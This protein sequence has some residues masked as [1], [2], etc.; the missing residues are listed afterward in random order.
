M[1]QSTIF[2]PCNFSGWLNTTFA[3]QFGIVDIDWSNNK[4]SWTEASPMNCQETLVE[5]AAAIKAVNPDTR[6]WVYR[7]LLRCRGAFCSKLP[8]NTNPPCAG[9]VA[10]ALP[11]FTDVRLKLDDPRYAG[12]FVPFGPGPWHVPNCTTT[13]G[14]TK[15]SQFYHD[16]FPWGCSTSSIC[17]CGNN[18]CGE[19]L[20]DFRNVTL[21]DYLIDE[22]ILGPDALG[23]PNITGFYCKRSPSPPRTKRCR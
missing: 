17:D 6:V 16:N 23:N 2:M 10:K 19:Y 11:W 1:Q 15:C 12:W 22:Y 9:N 18:P 14:G 4:A 5:Q 7:T 20:F 8:S 13:Q 3:A 21:L